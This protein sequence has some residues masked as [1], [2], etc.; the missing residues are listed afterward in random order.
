[1]KK[2][3]ST[4]L[5]C[6]LL[7]SLAGCSTER[8]TS[9]LTEESS[10]AERITEVS[11]PEKVM[12]SRTSESGESSS[13]PQENISSGSS[14]KILTREYIHR[15]DLDGAISSYYSPIY[16][17]GP[18]YTGFERYTPDGTYLETVEERTYEVNESNRTLSWSPLNQAST[19][20]CVYDEKGLLSEYKCIHSNGAGL[21]WYSLTYDDSGR[22]LQKIN[23]NEDGSKSTSVWNYTYDESG[24]IIRRDDPYGAWTEYTYDEDGYPLTSVSYDKDGEQEET[25]SSFEYVEITGE[26][27]P[28]FMGSVKQWVLADLVY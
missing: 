15:S 6:T 11:V 17:G 22:L 7:L 10:A 19:T 4:I 14:L 25:W 12:E 24:N 21:F 16:Q 5:A 28:G 27:L 18:M 13:A 1:M 20:T 2:R 26:E 9:E 23:V 3:I 8:S